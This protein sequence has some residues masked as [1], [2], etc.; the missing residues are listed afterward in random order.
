M[1]PEEEQQ[2]CADI[3][4]QRRLSYSFEVLEVEGDK[5]TI[6]T[7]FGSKIVYYKKGNHYYLE[8]D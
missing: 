5:Y 8:E 3:L 7:N 4:K 2:I 1:N 6:R